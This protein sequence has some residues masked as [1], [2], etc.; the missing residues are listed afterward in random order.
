MM[1]E[2]DFKCIEEGFLAALCPFCDNPKDGKKTLFYFVGVDQLECDVCG[3]R[4]KM[5]DLFNVED[6]TRVKNE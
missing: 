5:C 2:L 1:P 3:T 4:G 6:V